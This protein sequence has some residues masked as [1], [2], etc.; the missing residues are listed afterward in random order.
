MGWDYQ[1][2]QKIKSGILVFSV[3]KRVH[4]VDNA[5]RDWERGEGTSFDVASCTEVEEPIV[6]LEI[7]CWSKAYIA[8]GEGLRR[9]S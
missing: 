7:S 8:L 2:G 9:F 3:G 4:A 1:G 5:C 6:T